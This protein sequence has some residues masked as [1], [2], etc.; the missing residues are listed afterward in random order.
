MTDAYL[1]DP[2]AEVMCHECHR[3]IRMDALVCEIGDYMDWLLLNCP[4]CGV[5]VIRNR[6]DET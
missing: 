3:W 2:W 4:F 6:G 5:V 1:F